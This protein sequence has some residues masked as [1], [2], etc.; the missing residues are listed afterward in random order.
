VRL[1]LYRR[2]VSQNLGPGYVPARFLDR[3]I[4]A[5]AAS[6]GHSRTGARMPGLPAGVGVSSDPLQPIGRRDLIGAEG[7]RIM[8]RNFRPDQ[9]AL[10]VARMMPRGHSVGG[11]ERKCQYH[12]DQPSR[13]NDTPAAKRSLGDIGCG[14]T[15]D[16]FRHR[17]TFVA[18]Q[19]HIG[20]ELCRSSPRGSACRTT[21]VKDH[22]R[23]ALHRR[24]ARSVALTAARAYAVARLGPLP[25]SAAIGS[26]ISW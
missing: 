12:R 24:G 4:P 17:I 5:A 1:R 11:R 25:R 15:F 23:N 19:Q 6:S 9:I 18:P 8:T 7:T 20:T 16:L 10:L 14:R 22:D 2:S 13:S 26:R 3:S 21:W